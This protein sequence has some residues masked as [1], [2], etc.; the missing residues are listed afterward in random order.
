MRVRLV[1]FVECACLQLLIID[2]F[3][4]E[5]HV[6]FIV[7]LLNFRVFNTFLIILTVIML[8]ISSHP[9]NVSMCIIKHNL[10]FL[11]WPVFSIFSIICS[12]FSSSCLSLARGSF[13]ALQIVILANLQLWT[14]VHTLG[15]STISHVL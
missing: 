13:L 5:F 15:L 9:N 8:R 1:L 3:L 10:I 14:N 7:F 2:L 6:L 11:L 12:S 4:S